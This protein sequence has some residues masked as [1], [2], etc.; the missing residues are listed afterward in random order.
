MPLQ[1]RVT[2]FGELIVTG[3]RGTLMG[4]RGCLHAERLDGDR[5]KR[6][7]VA[8][9]SELPPGVLV[10]DDESRPYLVLE[11]RLARWEPGGYGQGIAKPDGVMHVLTPKSIVRAIAKGFPVMVHPSAGSAA[12]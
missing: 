6:T 9:V 7:Y 3:S 2:P 12:R 1:N 5:R 10:A 8:P 4:N 11:P